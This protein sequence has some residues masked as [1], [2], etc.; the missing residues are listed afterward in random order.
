MTTAIKES[1]AGRPQLIQIERA[2]ANGAREE[3]PQV[4][5]PSPTLESLRDEVAGGFLYAHSRAN[6]N[7]NK[8]LEVASFSYALIELLN[9]R[10]LIT[11][12]ELDERKDQVHKRLAE[13]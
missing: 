10:G 11:I 2:R 13:K 1:P 5:L 12:E 9:E 6:A 8:L 7:S 4:E 3:R